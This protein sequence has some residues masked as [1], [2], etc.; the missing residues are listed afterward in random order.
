MS[1]YFQYLFYLNEEGLNQQEW[2]I[3][4]VEHEIKNN[5]TSKASF[6]KRLK[7]CH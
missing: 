5:L 2:L 6:L 7:S 1:A 3:K 4:Y